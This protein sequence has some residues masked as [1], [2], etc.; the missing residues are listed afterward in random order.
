MNQYVLEEYISK[1]NDNPILID[2]LE[3]SIIDELIKY[4]EEEIKNKE[5]LLDKLKKYS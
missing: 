3:E 4:L 5:I 1:L 2:N